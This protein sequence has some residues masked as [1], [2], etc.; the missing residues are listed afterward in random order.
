MIISQASL[1]SPW[2]TLYVCSCW[3]VLPTLCVCPLSINSCRTRKMLW[4]GPERGEIN[5][6]EQN[7]LNWLTETEHLPPVWIFFLISF[8]LTALT[9]DF[10]SPEMKTFELKWFHYHKSTFQT[11]KQKRQKRRHSNHVGSGFGIPIYCMSKRNCRQEHQKCRPR[12]LWFCVVSGRWWNFL[13]PTVFWNPDSP[14]LLATQHLFVLP[15][16]SCFIFL[17]A[18]FIKTGISERD[19]SWQRPTLLTFILLGTL[20]ERG[21]LWL[22]KHVWMTSLGP[23]RG[24]EAF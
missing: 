3:N 18:W 1:Y 19:S 5:Q 23:G 9:H 15:T 4:S 8:W 11:N 13:P 14:P 2:L 12:G 22:R 6:I 21:S 7:C 20:Q 24:R 17:Q 16:T 10:H